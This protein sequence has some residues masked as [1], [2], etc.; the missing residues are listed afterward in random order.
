MNPFKVAPVASPKAHITS[1]MTKTVHNMVVTFES[2]LVAV[3][4]SEYRNEKSRHINALVS[5]Q[6][7]GLLTFG[8]LAMVYLE[9][10]KL[11]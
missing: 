6:C 10:S 3:N 8:H 7:V 5:A 1:R 9:P 4:N 11:P 2:D